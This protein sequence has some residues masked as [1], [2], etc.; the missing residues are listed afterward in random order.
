MFN[1]Q[2]ELNLYVSFRLRFIFQAMP[3]LR[4]LVAGVSSLLPDFNLRSVFVRFVV[5]NGTH[6]ADFAPS[7]SFFT[8][9]YN[10]TNVP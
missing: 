1:V 2:C 4:Q 7:I 9:Q 6:G 3:W 10:F 5:G 8:G